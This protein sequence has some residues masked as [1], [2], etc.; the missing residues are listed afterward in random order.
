[1]THGSVQIYLW[2]QPGGIAKP[3]RAPPTK[4]RG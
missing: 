4:E 2:V 3:S 1:M